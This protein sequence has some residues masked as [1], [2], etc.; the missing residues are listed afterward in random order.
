MQTDMPL[1]RSLNCFTCIVAMNVA[2]VRSFARLTYAK[3]LLLFALIATPALAVERC[4]ICGKELPDKFYVM[5]DRVTEE[6]KHVCPTCANLPNEC[7]VCGLPVTGDYVSISDG[8][9]LC[10]RDAKTAVL[11]R[12]AAQALAAEVK[13]SLDRMFSRFLNFP[14]TN[15]EITVVDRVDLQELFKTAGDS[16]SCP[17]VLGYIGPVTNNGKMH[18]EMRLLSGLPRAQL[19]AVVAHEY[20]HA[21]VFENVSQRRRR[22][23]GHDAHEGFCELVAYMFITAQEDE[24][25]KKIILHNHYT[26]GQIDLF[27]DAE[28]RFGFNEVVDWIQYGTDKLL[29]KDE[30]NRIRDV[31]MPKKLVAKNPK[32]Y[33]VQGQ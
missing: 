8:R 9:F 11:D 30:P 19:K 4:A 20:T 14:G 24:E 28:R 23:L 10:A 25:Q 13:D 6:K 5:T 2:P 18:Y 22:T 1:L 12:S 17:N 32:P 33:R 27:I 29:S 21:W 15:V 7:F 3:F 26:R 31:E 16:Y